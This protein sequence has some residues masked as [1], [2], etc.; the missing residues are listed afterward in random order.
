MAPVTAEVAGEALD[1]ILYYPVSIRAISELGVIDQLHI[2]TGSPIPRFLQ[3]KSQLEYLIVTGELAPGSRLPSIRA[4]ARVLE[5]GPATVV[6]AYSELVESGL[7]VANGKVGFFVIG[8]GADLPGPHG[9]FRER[10][11]ELVRDAIRG[12]ISLE[13]LVEIFMAQVAENRLAL[14]DREVIFLCKRAGGIDELTV[15]LR[16]ALADVGAA[17][18]GV[19]VEDIAEDPKTWVPRCAAAVRVVALMFDVN[20]ARSLLQPSGIEVLPLLCVVRNDVRDRIIHLPPGTRVA[21]VASSVEFIDGM[22]TALSH[23]NPNLELVGGAASGHADEVRRIAASVDCVVYGT[24][25]RD[26]VHAE[27]PA[28]VEGIEFIYVPDESSIQRLRLLLREE[29]LR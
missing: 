25:S 16:A 17:V 19:A 5:I 4:V 1:S 23:L 27:L 3:L 13:Q 18:T 14:S 24:L 11:G 8:A 12:G 9:E 26:V 7:A 22:I 29:A 15:R 10:I 2:R 21:V 6:R 20:Q 28:A